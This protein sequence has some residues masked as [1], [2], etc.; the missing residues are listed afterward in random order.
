LLAEGG[1][2]R[3]SSLIVSKGGVSDEDEL[4]IVVED[5]DVSSQNFVFRDG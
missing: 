2:V 5:E 3:R 1:L 4:V